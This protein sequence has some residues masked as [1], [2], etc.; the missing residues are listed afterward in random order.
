MSMLPKVLDAVRPL[1]VSRKTFDVV[2]VDYGFDLRSEEHWWWVQM[3]VWVCILVILAI[4]SAIDAFYI[5]FAQQICA[6][7]E[8]SR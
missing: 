7:F 4:M 6:M 1:N 8:I 2:Q 3:H 5:V